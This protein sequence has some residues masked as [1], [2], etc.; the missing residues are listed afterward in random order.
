MGKRHRTS[1][2]RE[3]HLP[4]RLPESRRLA[5]RGRTTGT[6]GCRVRREVVHVTGL[7][8]HPAQPCFDRLIVRQLDAGVG[9]NVRVGVEA[10]V[11][12][13]MARAEEEVVRGELP[14][15]DVERV[16]TDLLPAR[17]EVLSV[18]RPGR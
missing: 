11:R 17:D 10:D 7:R 1:A 4:I 14:L 3:A 6:G 16:P 13:G 8:L 18:L 2:R 9:G 12:D 5:V 15:E